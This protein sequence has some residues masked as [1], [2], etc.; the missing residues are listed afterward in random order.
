MVISRPHSLRSTRPSSSS[1]QPSTLSKHLPAIP[2]ATRAASSQHLTVPDHLRAPDP[3][4]ADVG[5][6][7]D[8]LNHRTV[9][10]TFEIVH[11]DI[12]T[13]KTSCF[14]YVLKSRVSRLRVVGTSV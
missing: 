9:D 10:G 4:S 3:P 8:F 13:A 1:P 14:V 2:S 7:I 5:E 11:H 12:R 6:C